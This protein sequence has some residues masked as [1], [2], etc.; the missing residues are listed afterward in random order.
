MISAGAV[1]PKLISNREKN[2]CLT[3]MLRLIDLASL[4]LCTL[5]FLNSTDLNPHRE[6]HI[7]CA[8]SN[9]AECNYKRSRDERSLEKTQIFLIPWRNSLIDDFF[10][11]VAILLH[12]RFGEII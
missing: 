10:M 1:T 7:R 9:Y 6:S 11:F 8:S 12:L 5:V 4:Y 2:V 3:S